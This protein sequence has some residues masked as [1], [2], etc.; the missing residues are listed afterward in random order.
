MVEAENEL[1]AE[2]TIVPASP[3]PT[4]KRATPREPWIVSSEPVAKRLIP[5]LTSRGSASSAGGS[6]CGGNSSR[7]GSRGYPDRGRGAASEGEAAIEAPA[8]RPS[9]STEAEANT[10]TTRAAAA[11]GPGA[12]AATSLLRDMIEK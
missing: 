12:E 2:P 9:S 4:K 3:T 8:S 1:L 11:A 5:A 6:G 10:P 7:G